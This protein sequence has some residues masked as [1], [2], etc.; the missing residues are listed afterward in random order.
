MD[1]AK[2]VGASNEGEIQQDQGVRE[3]HSSQAK[4]R[5]R[6]GSKPWFDRIFTHGFTPEDAVLYFLT[7]ILLAFIWL[8]LSAIRRNEA[9]S[10]RSISDDVLQLWHPTPYD[11]DSNINM[12]FLR[13]QVAN[14]AMRYHLASASTA[15][16]SARQNIA[17]II[18]A[19]VTLLGS[20]IV[21]RGVRESAIS[22]DGKA[23]H[24]RFRLI[25]SSPG[26]FMIAIG[27][28]LV[29]FTVWQSGERPKLTDN[30]IICPT[31]QIQALPDDNYDDAS[32]DQDR[33]SPPGPLEPQEYPNTD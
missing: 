17:F 20:I 12:D 1:E 22:A 27:C 9:E 7:L 15:A 10:I 2:P 11:Q 6:T 32:I 13:A 5:S 30:G 16:I 14:T 23:G 26:V 31:C 33:V 25:T 21:I 29:A 18:G 24:I 28:A 3:A 4:E 8:N 19:L